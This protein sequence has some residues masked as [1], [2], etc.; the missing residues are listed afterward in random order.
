MKNENKSDIMN[1][2]IYRNADK[3]Y[4]RIQEMEMEERNCN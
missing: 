4:N 3:W 2:M 1:E